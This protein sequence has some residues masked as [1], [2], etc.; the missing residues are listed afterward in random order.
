MRLKKGTTNQPRYV[1]T[2]A[3][4]VSW[5]DNQFAFH[6]TQAPVFLKLLTPSH[7]K[8]YLKASETPNKEQSTKDKVNSW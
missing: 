2:L 4:R 1:P 8:V 7:I 5:F 6:S 3:K